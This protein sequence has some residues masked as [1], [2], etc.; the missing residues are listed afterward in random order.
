MSR[1]SNWWL[2]V[3]EA[4][5]GCWHICSAASNPDGGLH[6]ICKV[7]SR[8]DGRSSGQSS[9]CK[10]SAGAPRRHAHP[11]TSPASTVSTAPRSAS[12]PCISPEAYAP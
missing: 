7:P 8:G 1:G 6:R 10:A 3:L 5:S 2:H 12:S 4:L 11:H 9:T